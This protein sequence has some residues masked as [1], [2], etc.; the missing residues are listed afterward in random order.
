MFTLSGCTFPTCVSVRSPLR[1]T[2]ACRF[3]LTPEHRSLFENSSFGTHFCD[4]HVLRPSCLV[5]KQK[6]PEDTRVCAM[7]SHESAA[8]ARKTALAR[9][10]IQICR[11]AALQLLPLTQPKQHR[12]VRQAERNAGAPSKTPYLL[13]LLCPCSASPPPTFFKVIHQ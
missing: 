3:I 12:D 8:A 13:L 7:L 11:A 5:N 2:G 1:L 10:H 9:P 4:C 6:V